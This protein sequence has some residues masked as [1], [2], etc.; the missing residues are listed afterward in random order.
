MVSLL[1]VTAGN[2]NASVH[3]AG[4]LREG[5]LRECTDLRTP[6]VLSY[7]DSCCSTK[8]DFCHMGWQAR[9]DRFFF[10]PF[11]FNEKP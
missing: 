1:S 2:S 3:R 7:M 6:P 4:D 5:G 10:F 9:V 8:V 11:L